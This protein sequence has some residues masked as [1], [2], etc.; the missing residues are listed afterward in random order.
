MQPVD[1]VL[2]RL[3]NIRDGLLRL[4]IDLGTI[5]SE[6]IV[7]QR[8]R[9]SY[10]PSKLPV[11]RSGIDEKTQQQRSE[12][13]Y[14]EICSGWRMLTDVRFKLL[15]LMPAAALAGGYGLFVLHDENALQMWTLRAII[16]VFG[17]VVTIGLMIY[18]QR[19]DGLYDD[20]I[21]RGRRIEDEWGVDTGLFRGRLNSGFANH[22]RGTW[23]V[24]SATLL[25]WT[26]ALGYSAYSLFQTLD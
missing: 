5:E 22:G 13:L 10:T 11:F 6:E 8:R 25:L 18:E 23:T 26:G 3:Q 20:M 19:N 21:S 2:R 15:G 9:R 12:K 24:Y 1:D 7:T 14:A 4:E 17:L 16:S